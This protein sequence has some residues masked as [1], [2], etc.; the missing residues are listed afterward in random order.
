M[1]DPES[2]VHSVVVSHG[3]KASLAGEC[4]RAGTKGGGELVE[5][6][7][8]ADNEDDEVEEAG[9]EVHVDGHN[10][11]LGHPD[12]KEHEERVEADQTEGK[13]VEEGNHGEA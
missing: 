10:S 5:D 7:G 6:A 13:T 12:S 2:D 4:K 11:E 8:G 9:A 3:V 1:E